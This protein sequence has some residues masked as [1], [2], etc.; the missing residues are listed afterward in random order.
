MTH[1][2]VGCF[3]APTLD[4]VQIPVFPLESTLSKYCVKPLSAR[5]VRKSFACR[6]LG[7]P[8]QLGSFFSQRLRTSAHCI[9]ISIDRATGP[10]TDETL[11][12]SHS[13]ERRRSAFFPTWVNSTP[14]GC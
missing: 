5:S 10:R 7:G 9:G 12:A 1:A 2:R 4:G 11:P 13:P 3:G 14:A 6:S 8:S